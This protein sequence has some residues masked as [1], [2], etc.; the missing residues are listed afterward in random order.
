MKKTNEER[1]TKTLVDEWSI[2]DGRSTQAGALS[3]VSMPPSLARFEGTRRG[4]TDR[5]PLAR[6]N[7]R[8]SGHPMARDPVRVRRA[9]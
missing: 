7:S 9:A 3:G 8:L 6:R 4:R 2:A 5:R 1:V